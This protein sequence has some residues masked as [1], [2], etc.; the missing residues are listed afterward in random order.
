MAKENIRV[1][2]DLYAYVN[3][4]WIKK[5]KIPDDRPATGG[6]NLLNKKVE[7]LLL[8]D[9]LKMSKREK[10]LRNKNLRKAV[11]LFNLAKDTDRRNSEG[12]SP[13]LPDLEKIEA[14]K[15]V[16]DL[17]SSLAE[18]VK[19]GY[20]LPFSIHVEENMKDTRHYC[21]MLF[22]PSVFLPD[23]TYYKAGMEEQK[24]ALIGVFSAMVLKLLSYTGA[25]DEKAKRV[26]D[27]AL[28]FDELIAALVKSSEEWSEYTKMYNPMKLSKIAS[29]MKP[30]GLKG[31]LGDLFGGDA[32]DTVIVSEPRY[33]KG[34]NTVFNEE[35]FALYRSWAYVKKLLA[36]ASYLSE[37]IRETA[38][39]YK[40][41]ISGVTAL[42]TIELQA[43]N[44]ASEFYSETI[45]L[46]YGR[47]YFGE[48]AKKDIVSMVGEII[49]TYKKRVR[50]SDILS[51]ST[52]EKAILK[53]S[54][55]AVKMGYPDKESKLYSK[56][57]FDE[58]ASL[59]GAI[60][61]LTR[62][63]VEH[64]L[65]KLSKEVDR[66]EW[67]MPGHMVN[68][69][70][71]PFSNDIT[72]PAAILQAPFYSIKQSR[73][74]NLGGIGAVIGHEIS[75]AFD[76]NGA[77]CDENGNLNNWWTKEDFSKFKSK[78][79]AMIRE[80]EGIELPW[81][82]VNSKFIVSE[83]IADNGGM[84]VT[85]D[86]MRTMEDADYEAYFYNWARIWCMKG[87][88]EY[89]KL[90]LQ[91]DVHAPTVLRA[92]MQPRNFEEWYATFGVT[93]ND[94]MYIAPSKRVII[95]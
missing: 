72:F 38:S 68:A 74:E 55:I 76:N 75:H 41:A 35:N 3:S 58:G 63:M 85:L 83:N 67:V 91:V 20:P 54:T 61:S 92:N 15:D 70:Y 94:K 48:E 60:S 93:R 34:F 5:A 16:A 13:V 33:F 9:F 57:V 29:L 77:M 25:D 80:F 90:L 1:Q 84:A 31:L 22:G 43:Y 28:R 8:R 50:E 2:D 30:I 73:S 17:T 19:D 65:E 82:K 47:K 87:R 27:E 71:N 95:W 23:T 7:K 46:Y 69:C 36:S 89:L 44:I 59:Y 4:A 53:L 81:G 40:K 52:K 78:T 24:Q 86:I 62:I 6:F 64:E 26:L 56:L 21:V 45:G 14:L 49:E 32:P 51:S 42:P 39:E 18:F 12:I 88:E 66:T 37:E 79:R 11:T 10:P